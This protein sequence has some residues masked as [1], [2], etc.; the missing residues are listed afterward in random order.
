MA[1]E[2]RGT[3]HDDPAHFIKPRRRDILHVGA[4]GAL[5]LTLGDALRLEA[6][7]KQYESKVGPAKRV[8]QIFLS[9]GMAAQESFDPKLYAPVEYR[10]PFGHIKTALDGERFGEPFQHTAKIADRLTVVRS[11]THNEAAHQRGQHNMFT[12]YQPSPAIQYP[13]MGSVVAHEFGTRN[14]L[15]PYVTVPRKPN[16][17]AGSGYLSSAYGPF[18]LGDNPSSKNF[19]VRDLNLPSGVDETRFN[20]RRSMLNAVDEHFRKLEK[21]GKLDAMDSFYEKAYALEKEPQELRKRYGMNSAGQRMLMCRRLVESGVR[22][23]TM[24]Y[25]GWDD[26]NNIENG[27]NNRVPNLDKAFATLINDLEERGLLDETLVLLTTEFGRTPKINDNAG[28]DHYPKV[29]S[30]AMAG[31]GL[32]KGFVYGKSNS[33]STEPDENP[34]TVPDWA[35]TVYNQIGI[36][37]EKELMAPG[38][39]PIEIVK[40]GKV[41][42]DL[43]A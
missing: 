12:G 40:G 31:G 43:I 13:S 9:G 30:I 36:N 41:V 24:N 38:D 37:A 16:E 11:M 29:F 23:V 26:H 17:H 21:S 7:Q 27:M 35:T 3:W 14:N 1:D 25:G 39:R 28:R 2:I 15:P 42:R 10:G 5:G 33:T 6:A 34:V 19:Q 20:R 4:I 22:F 8:I 32:K 18:S